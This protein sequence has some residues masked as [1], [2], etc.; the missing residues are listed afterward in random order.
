M[1]RFWHNSSII[2]FCGLSVVPY[3]PQACRSMAQFLFFLFKIFRLLN[4]RILQEILGALKNESFLQQHAVHRSLATI[5]IVWNESQ[6]LRSVFSSHLK[7]TT[8]VCADTEYMSSVLPTTAVNWN[9]PIPF[10]YSAD[11]EREREVL[12]YSGRRNFY[13]SVQRITHT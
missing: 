11:R 10:S 7:A 4:L 13:H 9:F 5:L 12:L 8:H 2:L 3:R 1:P 6:L